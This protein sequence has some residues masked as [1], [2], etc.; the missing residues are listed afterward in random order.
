[1]RRPSAYSALLVR[2]LSAIWPG[3]ALQSFLRPHY[4]V[5]SF[6]YG[7]A[8]SLVVSVLTI[9]WSIFS[10]GRVAPS[11]LLAG[12]TT[13]D[14]GLFARKGIRWSVWIAIVSLIGAVVLSY[15]GWY[16]PSSENQ[17]MTFF[18]AGALLLSAFLAG[19]A[20]WMGGARHS[21]VEGGGWWGTARLGVRNA[22]RH[23]VRSLLTAGMLASAAFL[24]VSVEAFRQQ[25]AP[26][27]HNIHGPDGGFALVADSDLPVVQ[28]LNSDKGRDEISDKIQLQFQHKFSGKELEDRINAADDLLTHTTIYPF[29]VHAGDDISCLNLYEPHRPRLLGSAEGADPARRLPVCRH[30]CARLKRRTPI[31]GRSCNGRTA[32]CRRSASKTAS[33]TC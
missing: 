14:G 29:R 23:R 12:Q 7:G 4:T 10:L 1:M 15:S 32:P 33:S 19:A 20:A 24:I 28:D 6:I 9:L 30:G 31:R 2:F 27:G 11:S 22:A 3:G 13:I 8:A 17:A 18:G 25:A 26:G 21:L 16:V 5:L